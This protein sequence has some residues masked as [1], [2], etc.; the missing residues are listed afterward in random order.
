[1]KFPG[2][3]VIGGLNG[4]DAIISYFNVNGVPTELGFICPPVELFELQLNIVIEM[5]KSNTSL[6]NIFTIFNNYN[7]NL[8]INKPYQRCNSVF[9]KSQFYQV[10]P[11]GILENTPSVKTKFAP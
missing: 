11:T 7:F 1:M 10:K 9:Q 2:S 8:K 5:V 6:K 4:D 3:P